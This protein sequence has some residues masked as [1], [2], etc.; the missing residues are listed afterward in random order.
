MHLANIFVIIVQSFM[1]IFIPATV[2]C[3]LT[4]LLYSRMESRY[5][6]ELS[7]PGTGKVNYSYIACLVPLILQNLYAFVDFLDRQAFQNSCRDN[8]HASQVT[9]VVLTGK[10]FRLHLSC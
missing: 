4:Y 10:L 5:L 9:A 6:L 1:Y 8:W 2:F 3:W 7:A